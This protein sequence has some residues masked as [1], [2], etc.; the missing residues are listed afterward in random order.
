MKIKCDI[1]FMVAV[2][3]LDSLT[4]S[5]KI[6]FSGIHC[7]QKLRDMKVSRWKQIN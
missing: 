7:E 1:G 2:Q 4:H 6:T 5:F 3:G